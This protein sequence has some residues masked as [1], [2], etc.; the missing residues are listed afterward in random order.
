MRMMRTI[1]YLLVVMMSAGIAAGSDTLIQR[2]PTYRRH[3][4]MDEPRNGPYHIDR[5]RTSNKN[6]STL[7]GSKSAS[8]INVNGLIVEKGT[9]KP[10]SDITLYIR[11]VSTGRI[12]ATLTTDKKGHFSCRLLPRKYNLIVAAT[13]YD[14]LEESA[15]IKEN[16]EDGLLLRITPKVFNPYQIVV[17]RKKKSSEVSHQQLSMPEAEQIA[18]S[19]RDVLASVKNMPGITSLSVFNG[20]GNGIVIRGSA[21]EDSLFLV[22]DHSI[23]SYYHFQ[24][25]ESIIEPEMVESVDYIA[26]G[27]S[28][29][30]GDTLG[31]V[32]S[33]NLRDPRTDRL[34]GYA[35]LSLL[36][37]SFLVEGP[38]SEKDSFAFGMKRGF[39]DYYMKIVE[40][41]NED[42]FDDINFVQYPTYY[43]GSALYRHSISPDN[44]IKLIG[45]GSNDSLKVIE[46]M[47]SVS[48]RTSD[49]ITM[50]DRFAT[51]IGEWKVRGGDLTSVFSPMLSYHYVNQ[52]AGDRA[53]FKQIFRNYELYEKAIYQ[54]NPSHRFISG[55][56]LSL[57]DVDL[58]TNFF[59]P[60]KEGE[61]A[62]D[63]Y[64]KELRLQ[65]EFMLLYPSAYFMDQIQLG[66]LMVTPG[67]NASYDTH[68]EHEL[69]DPRLSLKYQLN[70]NTALKAATGL[71]SKMPQLDESVA[72]FGTKGLLPEKAIHGVVGLEHYF[73]K[74]LF[75]DIQGYY[76]HFY[77]MVVRID[78]DDPTRYGNE[79]TGNAYGAEILLRH[80][81]TDH[82]FGWMAY[83]YSVARRKDGPDEDERFFDSDMTHNLKTVL[84]YKLNRY[85]SFGLRYEYASGTPYT[86]LLNVETVYDVDNDQYNPQYDGPINEER[87]KPRHQLD[88][89]IDKYWLFN[90][91]ILSSY[92]DY[93]NVLR[94]KNVVGINYNQ[95]YT[96]S[97]ELLDASSQV[98][99]IFLGL[100]VDF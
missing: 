32:V 31:G 51:L 76:K 66:P 96:Q 12:A 42:E 41:Y 8:P 6:G 85:W 80:Q 63:D 87:L 25:F 29:E 79:G 60:N 46:D 92:V 90:N 58:D 16:M 65:K 39:L 21:Q 50:Q 97:E 44:E 64:L 57:Y 3:A 20:Y 43:D 49:H 75:M 47:D 99:L 23:P 73:S 93:R 13:G 53:Y 54:A 11:D 62:N 34:G 37:S 89:R 91:F 100:K 95:D 17:R 27:F 71:Y 61:I 86:D 52:D 22:N 1:L 84:S 36:S 7:S 9:R 56:R 68:N 19:N 26:G 77:D 88:L 59:V 74:T 78:D 14:K 81:M 82:F 38:I 33:F 98:P 2:D 72:P 40:A 5:I 28:A 94:N 35:N 69:V 15:E 10:L 83:S 4:K 45:L 24:G 18:G 55:V 70:P 67:V 30:Y 48:E